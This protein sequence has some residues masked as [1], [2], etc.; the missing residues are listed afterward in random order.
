M[1]PVRS[2]TDF[3][4][5]Y[6]TMKE[7]QRAKERAIERKKRVEQA[8]GWWTDEAKRETTPSEASPDPLMRRVEADFDLLGFQLQKVRF[9]WGEIL[10]ALDTI[11]PAVF[12]GSHR[13]R[14]E[15]VPLAIGVKTLNPNLRTLGLER[16]AAYVDASVIG[17]RL[18]AKY[19]GTPWELF[20]E[21]GFFVTIK[22]VVVDVRPIAN[23]RPEK[24]EKPPKP[25]PMKPDGPPPR[26]PPPS[27]PSSGGG[28]EKTGGK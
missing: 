13:V 5:R 10:A 1:R 25:P 2:G 6:E 9:H 4:A 14:L 16:A 17:R 20:V 11:D 15:P 23:P 26:P 19:H 24:G 22:A 7:V 8:L 12:D 3:E 28:S 27:R 18:G 21:K